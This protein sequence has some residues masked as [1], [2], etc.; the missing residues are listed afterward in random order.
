M[1]VC[2]FL[3]FAKTEILDC[4]VVVIIEDVDAKDFDFRLA[5]K[6]LD[7]KVR[8]N[9]SACAGYQNFHRFCLVM[10]LLFNCSPVFF[11]RGTGDTGGFFSRV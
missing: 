7:Y 3:Y 11:D 9:K 4:R 1:F 5:L 2:C 8:A 10:F 6:K